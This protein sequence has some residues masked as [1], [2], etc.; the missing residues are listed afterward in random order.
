MS[1]KTATYHALVHRHKDSIYS[2]AMYLLRNRMDAE[3]VTQEVLIRI[4]NH[5]GR[6]NILSARSWIM[7]TTN[8]LCIDVIRK[9]EASLNKERPL[10]IEMLEQFKD[11][12]Q[13]RPAQRAELEQMGEKIQKSIQKLPDKMRSVFVLY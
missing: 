6:F 3:D 13:D 2:Y 11:A 5:L 7:R 4:W 10:K 1:L 9:R 8:N 12:P